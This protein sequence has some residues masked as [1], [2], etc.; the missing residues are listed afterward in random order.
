MPAVVTASRQFRSMRGDEKPKPGEQSPGGYARQV[1]QYKE[2][3]DGRGG[4]HY[5][6]KYGIAVTGEGVQQ[7][8]QGQA[9]FAQQVAAKA[10]EINNA[11]ATIQP[12]YDT[13]YATV[14]KS[15]NDALSKIGNKKDID[16]EYQSWMKTWTPFK[17]MTGKSA[18]SPGKQES[19]VNIPKEY[20]VKFAQILSQNGYPVQ[21]N[22]IYINGRGKE[23]YDAVNTVWTDAKTNW[24]SQAGKEIQKYNTSVDTAKSTLESQFK[25]AVA[26]LNIQKGAAEGQVSAARQGLTMQQQ[27][28]Q[29][30]LDMLRTSYQD[31]LARI[32]EALAGSIQRKQGSQSAATQV[33]QVDPRVSAAQ[34]QQSQGVK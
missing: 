9:D 20:A 4:V 8:D 22:N 30:Q 1:R 33:K 18:S 19:V 29:K 27:E 11:A 7:L 26:Q 5:S 6:D 16:K 31:R 14:V 17:V 15:R 28:N 13:S 24:Y 2:Q 23:M 12:Q 25:D 21:S 34:A 3:M 32:S 10:G